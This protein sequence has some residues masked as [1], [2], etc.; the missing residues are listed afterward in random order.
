MK[1]APGVEHVDLE[2]SDDKGWAYTPGVETVDVQWTDD[3]GWAYTHRD[4]HGHV[5]ET[6]SDP[7]A[8]LTCSRFTTPADSQ[9]I[10]HEASQIW[11]GA[12]IDDTTKPA[13]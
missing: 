4:R 8:K 12:R 7:F 13:S 1:A 2:W 10:I 9:S 11:P 6:S 5:V 3:A